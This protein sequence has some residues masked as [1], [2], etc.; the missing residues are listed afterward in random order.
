MGREW[1][2]GDE[3]VQQWTGLSLKSFISDCNW[4]SVSSTSYWR[5][6]SGQYPWYWTFSL[7][8]TRSRDSLPGALG[9]LLF[10]CLSKGIGLGNVGT[11]PDSEIPL[12][13]EMKQGVDENTSRLGLEVIIPPF[14]NTDPLALDIFPDKMKVG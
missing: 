13:P 11:S 6:Q 1:D 7:K 3:E 4:S 2:G 14:L 12:S 9:H 5:S 8:R 10:S